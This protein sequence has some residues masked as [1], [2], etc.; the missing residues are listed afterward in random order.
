MKSRKKTLISFCFTSFSFLW[1]PPV[2][3]SIPPPPTI[4]SHQTYL[5]F[6]PLFS[7]PPRLDL[8]FESRRGQ[9]ILFFPDTFFD[10]KNDGYGAAHYKEQRRNSWGRKRQDFKPSLFVIVIVELEVW[11]DLTNATETQKHNWHVIVSLMRRITLELKVVQSSFMHKSS[12]MLSVTHDVWIWRKKGG[13][14][15]GLK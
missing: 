6:L 4:H 5:S 7:S 3:P 9:C 1:T 2:L 14:H 8:S 10:R 12:T 13:Q 11:A 15:I